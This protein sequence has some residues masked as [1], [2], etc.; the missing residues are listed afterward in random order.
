MNLETLNIL[1]YSFRD[2]EFRLNNLE[3]LTV[4]AYIFRDSKCSALLIQRP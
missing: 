1:H 3:T 2:R 4:L